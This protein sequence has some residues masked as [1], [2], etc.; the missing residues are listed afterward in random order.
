MAKD[1]VNVKFKMDKSSW[2]SAMAKVGKSITQL[3]ITFRLMFTPET[4]LSYE[5]R[6]QKREFLYH[7]E[8]ERQ[9]RLGQAYVRGLLR[10]MNKSL[11]ETWRS[12]V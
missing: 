4:E 5:D 12:D 10:V 2:S 7:Q 6:E 8:I 3:G 1:P 11:P 9:R